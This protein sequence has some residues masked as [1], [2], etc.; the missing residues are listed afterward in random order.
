M[1]SSLR[2]K[3]SRVDT[4]AVPQGAYNPMNWLNQDLFFG[5][6]LGTCIPSKCTGNELHHMAATL[7]HRYGFHT[8]VRGCEV[9]DKGP[10]TFTQRGIM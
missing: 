3:C 4:R 2:G 6:Q 1:F 7:L 9:K 10:I 8:L 5:I